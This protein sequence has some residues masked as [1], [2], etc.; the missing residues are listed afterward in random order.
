MSLYSHAFSMHTKPSHQLTLHDK[1]SRLSPIQAKKLLGYA[2]RFDVLTLHRP[3]G[4][5]EPVVTHFPHAF[6]A[7]GRFQMHS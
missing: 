2:T 1:L 4:A 6:E 7:I 3:E 5:R